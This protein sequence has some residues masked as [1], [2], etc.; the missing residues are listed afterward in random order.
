MS[1][2]FARYRAFFRE[3][4]VVPLLAMAFAARMP[5]GMLALALLMHL[6][7]LSGSFAVAGGIV[8]AYMVAMAIG[9]P[10]QGRLVD[11]YGPTWV[12]RVNGV[13]HPLALVAILATRQT[14]P[15]YLTAWAVVAGAFMPPIAVLTRTVW[16]YRFEHDA[17]R[18]AF[19]LDAVLIELNYTLGPA[20]IALLLAVASPRVALAGA[21]LFAAT[22]APLY[23]ASP[24]QR[25]WKREPRGKR[26]FLGPL[27]EPQ[28]L[29]IFASN[30]ALTCGLGLLE[31]SYP[32]FAARSGQPAL[33]GVLIAVNS[34]G[35][36][37]GGV[38]YGGM[39]LAR[40]LPH[41]LR[42]LLIALAVP[43]VLHAFIG[44]FGWLLPLAFVAGLLIAPSF[45]IFSML[46][47]QHAPPRYATEA[48]TWA[49]TGIVAGIGTG[50][51]I[52][53]TLIEQGGPTVAFLASAAS[54]LVAGLLATLVRGK[55]GPH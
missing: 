50:M 18:M 21:V 38:A 9:A 34:L 40:P 13:V 28:L 30:F 6:R 36:A 47:A 51:A 17:R 11:R 26:H 49:T 43:L 2:P 12:L 33:G 48:F 53:G 42:A 45:A 32:G 1:S 19:A 8:G 4:D 27:T 24:A 54:V 23:L 46:V 35:S 3:P 20:L 55:P 7:S 52:G 10:I 41:Q 44:S 5:I 25:Y 16:R 14:S 15:A 37:A 22:A 29:L 39:H 31:V